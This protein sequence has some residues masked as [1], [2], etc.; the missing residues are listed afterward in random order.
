MQSTLKPVHNKHR[1]QDLLEARFSEQQ[2]EW[3][4]VLDLFFLSFFFPS[5]NV[6]F[7]WDG[8][9]V[10]EYGKMY[11]WVITVESLSDMVVTAL[12]CWQLY[13]L[14]SMFE[15]GSESVSSNSYIACLIIAVWQ[16][17]VSRIIT[18]AKET[19]LVHGGH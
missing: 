2:T 11:S 17:Y 3:V 16:Q 18:F 10:T 1:N 9:F 8:L 4:M 15:Q 12:M 19:L 7:V 5:P 6:V 13:M 14:V